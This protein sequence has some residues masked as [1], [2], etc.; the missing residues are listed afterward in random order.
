V[1]RCTSITGTALPL[2]FHSYQVSYSPCGSFDYV[3]SESVF[4]PCLTPLLYSLWL[5][6]IPN[7][8]ELNLL[9]NNH[10]I[11]QSQLKHCSVHHS[12]ELFCLPR[13]SYGAQASCRRQGQRLRVA[14]GATAPG[15]ALEGAPRFRPKVVFVSLSSIPIE[16]PIL[17]PARSWSALGPAYC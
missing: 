16:I 2:H 5:H 6:W 8:L 17:W 9:S 13:M 12:V 10:P 11:Q 7:H 4:V 3:T 15:P 1:R 14:S